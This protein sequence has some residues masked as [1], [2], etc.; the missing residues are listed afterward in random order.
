MKKIALGILTLALLAGCGRTFEPYW[1]ILDFRVLAVKSSLPEIRPGQTAQIEALTYTNTEDP[2]TYQWEWCPFRT[3]GGDGF[4]CPLT[5]EELSQILSAQLAQT[6]GPPLMIPPFDFDLGTNETAEFSYPAP[7][8]LLLQY[9]ESIQAFAANAPPEIAAAVPVVDC[10][11]GLEVSLRLIATSGGKK[12]IVGKRINLWLG[13]TGANQNP[14]VVDIQIRP[15]D[16]ASA[17]FLR[18]QGVTWVQDPALE[19]GLWW[20]SIPS[21][22]SLD[23]YA[24]TTFETRALVDP[25]SIDIWEPPAP[26][27]AATEFLPAEREVVVYRWMTTTGTYDPSERI[28]KDTLNTL[29]LASIVEFKLSQKGDDGDF[30]DDGIADSQDPCP[31]TPVTGDRAEEDCSVEIWSIVRD[32]RLG[33]DWAQR[34]LKVVGVRK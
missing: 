1:R 2:I 21:N 3:S 31:A 22:G 32:G 12:I 13:S 29:E 27:G 25:V 24:N 5:P 20:V 33:A 10:S 19:P 15:A 28:F 23:V 18:E 7:Q 16:A 11:R 8:A 26:Q 17:A 30:D 4:E 34:S 14:E 9:C 6:D